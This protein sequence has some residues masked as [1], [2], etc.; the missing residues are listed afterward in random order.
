MR[1]RNRKE[2]PLS[3]PVVD[4]FVF[5]VFLLCFIFLLG[6]GI[7]AD[8][9]CG[10]NETGFH[11]IAAPDISIEQT[12]AVTL[13]VSSQDQGSPL[14]GVPR[15][16]NPGKEVKS[17]IDLINYAVDPMNTL[18]R[19]KAVEIASDAPGP[20]NIDQICYIYKYVRDNW[21]YVPDPRG[22]DYISSGNN[23]ITL[24]EKIA[25][26]QNKSV[27]GAGDCDDYAVLTA[28][29]IEAIGG[30]TRVVLAYGGDAG[31]AYT[32]VYLGDID[33]NSTK[34][35]LNWL[36]SKYNCNLV[37]GHLTEENKTFWL[38]LDWN[39]THPGGAL[40]KSPKQ[41]IAYVR[42]N[43]VK[44][45]VGL[46]PQYTPLVKAG[47]LSCKVLDEEGN[48]LAS[49][50]LVTRGGNQFP[51]SIDLSGGFKQKLP[52]GDYTITASKSGYKFDTKTV[53]I[54]EDL[55]ASVDLTGT[56]E[57]APNIQIVTEAVDPIKR[58]VYY[59]RDKEGHQVFKIKVYVTGPDK[60]MIKSVKYSL[61][62]TFEK[63]EHISTES[64]NN[65]EMIM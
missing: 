41:S 63:P 29:L 62:Q 5:S 50:V 23:T 64:S 35:I 6:S 26:R 39:S 27:A 54:L 49:T 57:S 8:I 2:F 34:A 9:P 46:P 59:T 18:T 16:S 25:S 38:N 33:S 42:Q 61:H 47:M 32:E 10:Y 40:Y 3:K 44:T 22:I 48:P 21:E 52:V 53:T 36:R 24:A 43:Y 11:E 4:E 12:Q 28:S 1:N 55:E 14:A 65:F 13:S 20:F 56:R 51:V 30:T 60:Q 58:C 15:L 7:A 19:N 31:H 17:N 45:P 37:Y